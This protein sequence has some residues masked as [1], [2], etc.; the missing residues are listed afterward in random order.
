MIGSERTTILEIPDEDRQ[1]PLSILSRG[2]Q[3]FE[4]PAD[5]VDIF[6]PVFCCAP[7]GFEAPDSQAVALSF[8]YCQQTVLKL[9]MV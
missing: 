6:A 1:K 2:W 4:Q 7:N 3:D 5:L 8:G 9:R